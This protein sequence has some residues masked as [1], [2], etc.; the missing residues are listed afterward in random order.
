MRDNPKGRNVGNPRLCV[1]LWDQPQLGAITTP[2]PKWAK[3]G[4]DY[5]TQRGWPQLGERAVQQ[6]LWSSAEKHSQP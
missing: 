6:E 1:A 3:K 4:G 5:R 2:K